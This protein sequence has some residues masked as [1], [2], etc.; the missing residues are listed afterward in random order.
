MFLRVGLED[1]RPKVLKESILNN[2]HYEYWYWDGI[3]GRECMYDMISFGMTMYYNHENPGDIDRKTGPNIEQRKV[4]REPD[5]E[6]P[7]RSVVIIYFALRDIEP[8][9]ELLVDYGS[10]WFRGRGMTVIDGASNHDVAEAY[11]S[12]ELKRF[13]DA[14]KAETAKVAVGH[15]ERMFQRVLASQHATDSDD[16]APY[17]LETAVSIL[18]PKMV[19]FGRVLTG[20]NIDRGETID[21]VPAL[22]MKKSLVESSIL[23]SLAFSWEDIDATSPVLKTLGGSSSVHV[24]FQ[25]DLDHV[26]PKPQMIVLPMEE[27]VLFVLAGN[28]SL[29]ARRER[30]YGDEAFN[31]ILLSEEDPCNTHG[32]CIRVIATRPIERG[33]AIVIGVKLRKPSENVQTELCLTGQPFYSEEDDE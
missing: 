33:E 20:Q 28:I 13:H 27:S 22:L 4:G 19:I 26:T 11:E 12:E 29:M 18:P 31:A 24:Q 1:D 30:T 3:L 25:P 15:N 6:S 5:V 17:R 8:F 10:G 16:E 2:Y 7:G 21:F 14:M 9:E 32:Y 23:E